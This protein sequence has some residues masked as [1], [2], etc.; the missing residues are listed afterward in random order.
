MPHRGHDRVVVD[1]EEDIDGREGLERVQGRTVGPAE[2]TPA[3]DQVGADRAGE[4]LAEAFGE[5][6]RPVARVRQL[7]EREEAGSRPSPRRAAPPSANP[8]AGRAHGRLALVRADIGPALLG[9]G[10]G[11][12]GMPRRRACSRSVRPAAADRRKDERVRLLRGT[13]ARFRGRSSG[14]LR[15]EADGPAVLRRSRRAASS[16]A[17]SRRKVTPAMAGQRSA[18]ARTDTTPSRSISSR[19]A[20]S[21]SDL[22]IRWPRTVSIPRRYARSADPVNARRADHRFDR[23]AAARW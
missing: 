1:A 21:R 3:V 7:L 23:F 15:A 20:N 12:E 19:M 18:R 10:L 16:R 5:A 22:I 8:R 17:R 9:R 2:G 11:D 13:A 14:R 6:A 4:R